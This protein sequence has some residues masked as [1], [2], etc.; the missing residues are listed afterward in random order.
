MADTLHLDPF[1]AMGSRNKQ[2]QDARDM[3]QVVI[4]RAKRSGNAVPPYDFI[5]LIGKGSF[6]RV[7]KWYIS[8]ILCMTE[9]Y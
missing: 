5:E 7:Y 4:E 9:V 6:G 8:I 2:A 1:S 3:Q